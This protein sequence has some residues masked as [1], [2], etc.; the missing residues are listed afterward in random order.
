M[1]LLF[2]KLNSPSSPNLFLYIRCSNLFIIF[3]ALYWTLFKKFM[4][5]LYWGVQNLTQHYKCVSEV[6]SREEGSPSLAMN[7]WPNAAQ[8]AV[9]LLCCKGTLRAHGQLGVH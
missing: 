7:A 3:V 2:S 4:F 6:L 5:F 1:G 8:E 9:G